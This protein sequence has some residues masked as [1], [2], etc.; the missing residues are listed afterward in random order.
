M[1][2]KGKLH[3]NSQWRVE[4]TVHSGWGSGRE[5]DG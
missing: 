2:D 3:L 4:M 1:V 5:K